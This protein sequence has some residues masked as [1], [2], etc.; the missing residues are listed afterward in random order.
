MI[1]WN[2]LFDKVEVILLEEQ[3][4][5]T[6]RLVVWRSAKAEFE[7]LGTGEGGTLVTLVEG[8]VGVSGDAAWGDHP[9]SGWGF[10]DPEFDEQ[11]HEPI[12]DWRVVAGKD[13]N[14]ERALAA[15]RVYGRELREVSLA[16]A[17]LATGEVR[18]NSVAAVRSA[19]GTLVRYGNDWM[20][21][22]GSLYYLGEELTPDEEMVRA[23]RDGVAEGSEQTI[24]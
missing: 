3:R 23:L 8:L 20:R 17:I 11:T 9:E 6:E 4:L 18:A 14:R 15:A 5:S 2:L 21:A 12:Y 16:N 10:V 13:T 1:D 7:A 24:S 19:L 22:K